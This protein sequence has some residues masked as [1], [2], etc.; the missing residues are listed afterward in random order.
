MLTSFTQKVT[1]VA[2]I[3]GLLSLSATSQTSIRPFTQVYSEN[4]K[5]SSVI[6]GNTMMHIIDNNAVNTTKMN[7]TGSAGNG[8]GGFGFTQYGNNGENM[9]FTDIDAAPANLNVFSLGASGWKYLADGS[10]QGT[11]WRTLNSPAAPWV[12]ASAS[13]GYGRTQT[14][15]IASGNA[16]TYFLKN[17]SITNPSLYSSFNMVYSYDDGIVVYVNGVEVKRANMASGTIAFNTLASSTNYTTGASFSI[18]SSYFVAGNNII[19]AEV[20]QKT[21]SSSN[22][23]FDMSITG[24]SVSTKNSSSADL[25]LPAGTN[26]I[27]F[28]RLYWGGSINKS[29]VTSSPDTL[30]KI[31]IRKGTSGDYSNALAPVSNVD[32]FSLSNSETVYQSY[33]DVTSFIQASGAGTYTIAD[34]PATVGTSGVGGRFAGWAIVVAYENTAM[35]YTS[36]RIYD[37]YS[38]VFLSG[39][40]VT[41]TVVLSGL[42]VPNNPL[43]SSDAVMATMVWEGDGNLGATNSNPAGDYLKVNGIAVSNAV[44][45]V[46]NYWNGSISKNGS[47]VTGTKNPDYFNQMG[48]DIDEV[49]V[50]TGYNILPNATSA[51]IVFGTEAD[52]YFPSIFSFAIKMKDPVI[53][54]DKTV[55]DAN[56]DHNADANEILT[57]TLSGTNMG[58]GVAYNATIVD[59]LPTNVTYVP[60]TLEI[61]NA[62]GCTAGIKTDAGDA[63]NALKGTNAGRDFIKFFIGTGSTGTGGGQLPIGSSYELKFKVQAEAIP[64]SITNTAR[65]TANS[66][67]GDQFIDDGTAIISPAGG[68]LDVNLSSFTASLSN[69]NGLL[70]WV[71]ETEINSSRFEIERSDDAVRFEKRGFVNSNGNSTSKKTYNYTDPLNTASKVIYYRLKMI[72]VDGKFNY[73]KIIAIKRSGSLSAESFSVYPN[74]FVS[75]FKVKLSSQENIMATFR[76]LSFDGKEV[77]SRKIG[78]QKGE[79]IVVLKDFGILNRGNYIL[80]VTTPTDK[81]INKIMK[82]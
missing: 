21:A 66:Q 50:G 46:T 71:S 45:P 10:N 74:P 54:L 16:T 33:V 80:E 31:K 13:F 42:N 69:N 55:S 37:G 64:G 68:P 18:P 30:R 81:F 44:N 20:H 56:N 26:T 41:Q 36:V 39:S 24:I 70:T 12:S 73:S 40:P 17:I 65:I 59:S 52:Q 77:L 28:A 67:A 19:A 35:D 79:N 63:D 76:I 53:T 4:L 9:Q 29:V 1:F 49:N 3:T 6:F 48:L 25:I 8:Q 78:V 58:P 57:Y 11:S 34:L 43:T 14:T 27:K 82:N 2:I 51:T 61:V 72:D 23:F 75:D 38:Q 60:N 32:L 5:G 15:T 47:F 62:P 22:C 7:E